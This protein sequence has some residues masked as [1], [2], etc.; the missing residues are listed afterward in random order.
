MSTRAH[1]EKLAAEGVVRR[2]KYGW[3]LVE[4]D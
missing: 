1:L 2:V 3:Q 4:Q